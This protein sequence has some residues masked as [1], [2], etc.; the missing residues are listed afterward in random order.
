[1]SLF[2]PKAQPLRGQQSESYCTAGTLLTLGTW[3]LPRD[4]EAGNINQLRDN[5]LQSGA[6]KTILPYRFMPFSFNFYKAAS[7]PL[8]SKLFN[9]HRTF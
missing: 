8:L 3:S 9:Y 2:Y 1:M 4:D 5:E 6:D 7:Q